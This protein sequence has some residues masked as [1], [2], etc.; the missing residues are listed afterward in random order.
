MT[1]IPY[2]KVAWAFSI[3]LGTMPSNRPCFRW[4]DRSC[5]HLV[6][7][8]CLEGLDLLYDPRAVEKIYWLLQKELTMVLLTLFFFLQ[9][10]GGETRRF[11]GIGLIY[12]VQRFMNA[13][14][15]S[16]IKRIY[17]SKGE[18]WP[19]TTDQN[20][21][22]S[23][24]TNNSN[25]SSPHVPSRGNP[26]LCGRRSRRN[27]SH[28]NNLF[29]FLFHV[30]RVLRLPVPMR[31]RP[32]RFCTDGRQLLRPWLH[33][34]PVPRDPHSHRKANQWPAPHERWHGYPLS[35][36]HGA[37]VA[38]VHRQRRL[39]IRHPGGVPGDDNQRDMACFL[40][41]GGGLVA[42]WDWYRWVEG[43]AV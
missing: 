12:S 38:D 33:R 27:D 20:R 4:H 1:A 34:H 18:S 30:G 25:L 28:P 29:R 37:C 26:R 16:P 11:G 5:A 40:A 41:D 3:R 17:I 10:S 24:Q 36:W 23:N 43:S 19:S 42:A 35:L 15:T 39:R 22:Q 2:L 32:Q 7:S 14:Q 8:R 31:L 6:I 9:L 21:N 13:A